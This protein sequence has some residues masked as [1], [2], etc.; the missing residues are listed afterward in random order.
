MRIEGGV[1]RLVD[2][3]RRRDRVEPQV[4][5]LGQTCTCCAILPPP[6]GNWRDAAPRRLWSTRTVAMS[7]H[8]A[9]ATKSTTCPCSSQKACPGRNRHWECLGN[10]PFH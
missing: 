5:R 7:C 6:A 10:C 8:L 9:M 4:R 1:V 3:P 2:D